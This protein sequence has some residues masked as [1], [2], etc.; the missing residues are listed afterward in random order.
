[1]SSLEPERLRGYVETVLRRLAGTQRAFADHE[2]LLED[3]SIDSV[4]SVEILAGV[5]RDSGRSLPRGAE[6]LFSDVTTVGELIAAFETAFAGE[7]R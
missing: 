4:Q 7:R 1:M 3:L 5:E 6:R 2:R